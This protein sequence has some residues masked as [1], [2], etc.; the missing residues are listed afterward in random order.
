MERPAGVRVGRRLEPEAER[1]ERVVQPHER[2]SQA[3]VGRDRA[4]ERLEHP[5]VDDVG[6]RLGRPHDLRVA[7]RR[8]QRARRGVDEPG[9]GVGRRLG[10]DLALLVADERRAWPAAGNAAA[11]RPRSGTPPP[12][13]T[14][15][16]TTRAASRQARTEALDGPSRS[17]RR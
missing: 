15:C 1:L 2:R 10:G 4:Q 8:R 17:V 13:R 12:P 11:N 14:D 6:V 7:H 9:D 3:E 5:E 16:S